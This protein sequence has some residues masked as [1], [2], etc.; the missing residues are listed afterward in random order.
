MAAR[1]QMRPIAATLHADSLTSTVW[2]YLPMPESYEIF[3]RIVRLE[4]SPLPTTV[5]MQADFLDQTKTE[6]MSVWQNYDYL[7]FPSDTETSEQRRQ[8]LFGESATSRL[9]KVDKIGTETTLIPV[10]IVTN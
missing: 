4:L 2:V 6:L 5:V 1:V 7:W 3:K 10:K 9:M 8:E